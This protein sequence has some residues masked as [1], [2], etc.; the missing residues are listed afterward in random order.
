VL[1]SSELKLT[2]FLPRTDFRTSQKSTSNFWKFSKHTSENRNLSKTFTPRSLHYSTPRPIFSRI[3]SNSC[4]SPPLRIEAQ[5][6]VQT[7]D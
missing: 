1:S 7:R 2:E 4:P 3:L 6:N 5:G